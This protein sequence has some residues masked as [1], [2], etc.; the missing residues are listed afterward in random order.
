LSSRA[1]DRGIEKLGITATSDARALLKAVEDLR[2]EDHVL[3]LGSHSQ[4]SATVDAVGGHLTDARSGRVLVIDPGSAAS[5]QDLVVSTAAR[6]ARARPSV[7]GVVA[8]AEQISPSYVSWLPS[9][10]G[11]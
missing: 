8:S 6:A 9:V 10:S 3:I 11:G 7:D 1:H 2:T 4:R 5:A